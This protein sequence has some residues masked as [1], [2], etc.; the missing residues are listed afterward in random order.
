MPAARLRNAQI[1]AALQQRL[2]GAESTTL[3]NFA[4]F[5]LRRDA[6]QAALD[7]ARAA[8]A[9]PGAPSAAWRALERIAAGR[10]DGMLLSSDGTDAPDLASVTDPLA[11]AI[12]AH[13]ERETPMA[14]VCYRL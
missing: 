9:L 5:A 1:V 13:R 3:S 6:P 12:A 8:V 10:A 2:A 4:W 7:A 14:E 11:A